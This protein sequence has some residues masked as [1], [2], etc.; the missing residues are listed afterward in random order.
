MRETTMR[1]RTIVAALATLL[2][3]FLAPPARS[4]SVEDFYAGKALTLYIGFPVG[5]GYDLY[6]RL[7][8]RHIGK[9]IPGEPTVVPVNM[10]GAGSL[11]LMNWL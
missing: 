11:R 9:F 1:E 2:A 8:A 6:G 5:G 10:E 4:Q 3:L 7:V